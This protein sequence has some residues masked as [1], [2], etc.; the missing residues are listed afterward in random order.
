MHYPNRRLLV[1]ITSTNLRS[2]ATGG[3]PRTRDGDC[4]VFDYDKVIFPDLWQS[5]SEGVFKGYLRYYTGRCGCKCGSSDA[6]PTN[7]LLGPA[8]VH[9][10]ANQLSGRSAHFPE[11][12]VALDGVAVYLWLMG[13]CYACIPVCV[14]A[15]TPIGSR[16]AYS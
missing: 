2:R 10:Q 5:H 8:L 13:G 14:P 4:G 6:E 16:M 7:N 11:P 1:K 3:Q 15:C 12:L 9:R